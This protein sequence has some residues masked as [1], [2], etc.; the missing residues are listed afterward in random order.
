MRL[1]AA[2]L[3]VRQAGWL[4]DNGQPCSEAANTAKYLAA[5]AGF[6]AADRAM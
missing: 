3:M 6:F 4:Y 2:E 5:E 1:Q